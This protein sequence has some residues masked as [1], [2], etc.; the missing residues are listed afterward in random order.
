MLK[1]AKLA[2]ML[3]VVLSVI[4]IFSIPRKVARYFHFLQHYCLI[5]LTILKS[6][7]KGGG[8]G[9]GLSEVFEKVN[10]VTNVFF[11]EIL[12]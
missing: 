9:G 11:Q 8:G 1:L 5:Q 6:L 7:R 2:N 3:T 12:N 4:S 10:L